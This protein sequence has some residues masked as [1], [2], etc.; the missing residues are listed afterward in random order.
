MNNPIAISNEQ[1]SKLFPFYILI[2]SDSGIIETGKSLAKLYTFQ[3]GNPLSDFFSILRPLDISISDTSLRNLNNQLVILQYNKDDS[4]PKLRGQFEYLEHQNQFLFV[5]SPWINSVNELVAHNLEINDYAVHDSMIDLLHVLMIENN[6]STDLKHTVAT[7]EAQKIELNKAV[8]MAEEF[9]LFPKQNPHPVLRIDY[10]GLILIEN[11][12]SEKITEIQYKDEV[13]PKLELLRLL[14]EQ[15]NKSRKDLSVEVKVNGRFYNFLCI[16][17]EEKTYINIYGRDITNEKLI[18]E[19]NK[20]L[21]LVVEQNLNGITFTNGNG[22]LLWANQAFSAL[23]GYTLTDIIGKRC[24]DF[25]Y[26]KDTNTETIK[27][28]QENLKIGKA[29]ETE[30]LFYNK[31]NIPL[32]VNMNVQPILDEKGRVKQY[33]TFIENITDKKEKDR[34]INEFE[35][36]IIEALQ[37]IGDNLW[38]YD[39]IVDKSFNYKYSNQILGRSLDDFPN[40]YTL[41]KN[42]ILEDDF[43]IFEEV[44]HAY[45]NGLAEHHNVEYRIKDVDGKVRWIQDRGI[46][47]EKK[48]DGMPL[49]MMG[50][51]SDITM[52]KNYESTIENQKKFYERILNNLPADIAIFD[53]DHRYVFINESAVANPEMRKW[54]IGKNDYEYCAF[55]N[56]PVDIADYRRKIFD[57]VLSEVKVQQF[58]EVNYTS[59]GEEIVS[60]RRYHPYIN[61]DNELEF[62]I[63][64]GIDISDLKRNER[65]LVESEKKYADII[66]NTS[67][68]VFIIDKDRH[69]KFM[70]RAA[71]QVFS[72]NKID[73]IN[74]AIGDIVNDNYFNSNLSN[75][76]QSD[77][78]RTGRIITSIVNA[79][80]KTKHLYYYMNNRSSS[81]NTDNEVHIFMSDVT[82][83]INAENELKKIIAKERSLNSLK[84]EFVNMVSHELRTPLTVILSSV[85]LIDAMKDA[86]M[87]T[88]D[89]LS[90]QLLQVKGEVNRMVQLMNELLIVSKIETG[91]IEYKEESIQLDQ[92]VSDIIK[93]QFAPWKDGRVIEYLNEDK[94]RMIRADKMMLRHIVQNV[95]ENA[96]KYS[97]GKEPPV[98]SLKFEAKRWH[99]CVKDFGIGIPEQDINR[100]Y[101]SFFR[102]SNTRGIPGTG[103]GLVITKFFCEKHMAA[104][105]IDS[106]ENSGTTIT[107]HFPNLDMKDD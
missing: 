57:K 44:A 32:W 22:E 62:I 25:L 35:K 17:V 23:T 39:F 75:L 7:I 97:A 53:R 80:S 10:E 49:R 6:V 69:I 98:L 91:K 42:V 71:E 102:A 20:R 63:G 1:F 101:K 33:F 60:L 40:T 51:H 48:P 81:S 86:A 82:E 70:N 65:L 46:I 31:K 88:E 52:L 100:L 56:K 16:P 83:Q 13:Y 55:K 85:E 18:E 87:L 41:F 77:N 28:I 8:K 26:G 107:I 99:L 54:L 47:I 19:K 15:M 21:S 95:V 74:R 11:Q 68:V 45:N 104:I 43:H 94:E 72:V 96:F 4:K 76:L 30:V 66:E 5:G 89:E 27:L 12:G 14:A 73:F 105:Q 3:I 64:Y 61:K 36:K 24:V 90:E 103:I 93:E 92:F 50:V 38:E 79:K 2:D 34:K 9:A 59:T 67:E 29:F 84:S 58:E 37:T 78:K 106:K